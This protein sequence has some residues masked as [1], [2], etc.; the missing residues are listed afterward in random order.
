M[1]LVLHNDEVVR[2]FA[3]DTAATAHGDH[4]VDT[5]QKVL[6]ITKDYERLAGQRL[7]AGTSK[8][9]GTLLQAKAEAKQL[10]VDGE[11]LKCV[12]DMRCLGAHLSFSH[13]SFVNKVAQ[14]V[15]E[16]A[17][18]RAR[19]IG[20]LPL[21]MQARAQLVGSMVNPYALYSFPSCAV[22][23]SSL[24]SLRA[25]CLSAVWGSTRKLKAPELVMTLI[26]K[27]HQVDPFQQAVL[28][29]LKL[30][31]RFLIDS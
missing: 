17:K 6:S 27:V 23:W 22:S 3:D 16:P 18:Q 15:L 12:D 20:W 19:R 28:F 10:H 9:W 26:V 1:A 13:S 2:A 8:C 21:P 4:V 30:L 11:K 31:R 14:Q 29:S 25:A 7:N 24:M 5:L